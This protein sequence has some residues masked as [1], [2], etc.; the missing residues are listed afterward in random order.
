MSLLRSPARSAIAADLKPGDQHPEA[1]ILF[2]LLLELLKTV[3]HELRDLAATQASHVDV[4]ASQTALV[5][6]AL[7]I[8]VHQVEFID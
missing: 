2:D 7:A 5:V 6:V 8:D 1:T 4:V 3:A